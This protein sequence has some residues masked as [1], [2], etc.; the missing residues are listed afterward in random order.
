MI[1]AIGSFGSAWNAYHDHGNQFSSQVMGS[2]IG[3][4]IFTFI[5]TIFLFNLNWSYMWPILLIVVGLM[6]FINS[7][8]KK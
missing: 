7:F 5:T 6:I 1:P 2:L 4:I 8:F 3:G